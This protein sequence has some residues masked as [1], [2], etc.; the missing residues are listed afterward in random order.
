MIKKSENLLHEIRHVY[1][2]P[3]HPRVAGVL[4]ELQDP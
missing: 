2:Q 4:H 1:P 3:H